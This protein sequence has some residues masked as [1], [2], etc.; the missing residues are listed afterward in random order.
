MKLSDVVELKRSV[1]SEKNRADSLQAELRTTSNKLDKYHENSVKKDQ[2]SKMS[3]MKAL[4]SLLVAAVKNSNKLEF[5]AQLQQM[6][7]RN[8]KDRFSGLP[9]NDLHNFSNIMQQFT[10]TLAYMW[11]LIFQ[12]YDYQQI[13]HH[14]MNCTRR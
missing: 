6:Q 11:W 12:T 9:I 8:K 3:Q 5:K 1:T 14:G 13:L 10:F 2:D 4:M 7:R